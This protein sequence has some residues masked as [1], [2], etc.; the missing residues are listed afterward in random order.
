MKK[1]LGILILFV[2]FSINAQS[3]ADKFDVEEYAKQQTE[4]IKS[5]LDLGDSMYEGLYNANLVK[6]YSIKKHIILFEQE[7]KTTGKTLKQV[8]ADVN[9]MAEK[10]SGY[11]DDLHRVLGEDLFEKYMDKFGK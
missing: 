1:Y 10:A 3:M 2:S 11:E 8:I 9:V 6:A 4:M 5:T 7:G